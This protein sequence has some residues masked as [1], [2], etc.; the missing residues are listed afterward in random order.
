[1]P[2]RRDRISSVGLVAYGRNG[3]FERTSLLTYF[4][5]W[6]EAMIWSTGNAAIAPLRD[7]LGHLINTCTHRSKSNFNQVF[8][9]FP[10]S[11]VISI[12]AV[13]VVDE[14]WLGKSMSYLLAS[15]QFMQ[16]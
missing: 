7:I 10:K 9:C 2:V 11:G 12:N 14:S 15:V 8:G 5:R 4:K 16:M 3:G 6:Q 1:M 13:L